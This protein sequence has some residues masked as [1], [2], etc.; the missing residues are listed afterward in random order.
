MLDLRSDA[1]VRIGVKFLPCSSQR[2]TGA[3]STGEKIIEETNGICVP[4]KV[5]SIHMYGVPHIVTI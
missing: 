4:D 3:K 5:C 2:W 1:A